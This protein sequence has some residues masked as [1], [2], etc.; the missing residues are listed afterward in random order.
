[1][2]FALVAVIAGLTEAIKKATNMPSKY[3]PIVAILCGVIIMLGWEGITP[4]SI[5]VGLVAGLAS[6]G[7]YD[8]VK[9][10]TS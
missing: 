6:Q 1:M 7:L 3:S 9:S 10:I 5:L 2:G 4:A 8:N